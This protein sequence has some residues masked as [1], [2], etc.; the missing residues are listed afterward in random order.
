MRV[1]DKELGGAAMRLICYLG[2]EGEAAAQVL[3]TDFRA[4]D[5][6]NDYAASAR[7]YQPKKRRHQRALPA[8]CAPRDAHLLGT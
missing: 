7:L 2:H 4:V 6:V 3:K 1:K 8:P 5:A